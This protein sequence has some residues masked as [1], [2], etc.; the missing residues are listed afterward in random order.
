LFGQLLTQDNNGRIKPVN[1]LASEVLRKLYYK[2]TYKGMNPDQVLLGMFTNPFAWQYEPLIRVTH[3]QIKKILGSESGKY[4]S[5]ASFF[6]NNEYL[7]QSYVNN[8]YN[9]SP[10]SRNKFDNEMIRVDERVNISYMIFS[11]DLLKILPVPDDDTHTWYSYNQIKGKVG[12]PDSVFLENVIL[13][14]INDVRQALNTGDWHNADNIIRAISGYQI[15]TDAGIVPSTSKIQTEILL[16]KTDLIARIADYY[17]IAG[18]I[19]LIFQVIIL[20]NSHVKLKLPVKVMTYLIV[21]LFIAH[22]FSLAARWYVSG[23]APWSNG[24]E[25]LIYLSWATVLAGLILAYRSDITMSATA[26]LSFLILRIAHLSFM[27]PQITN[28]VPVLKS[29]WLVLHVSVITASYGFLALGAVLALV[30]LLFM[31][32]FTRHNASKLSLSIRE[33][34]CIIEISLIIGLYLIA[35][36]TFLG[37]VWANES[38]GRYWGW[39]PKETWALITILVYAFIT[40]MQMVPSLKGEF[41]FNLASLTGISSVLMTFFGVNYYLSGLHSYA[42]SDPLKIPIFVYLIIACIFII[43]IFARYKYK[44]LGVFDN[45]SD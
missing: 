4:F 31:T 36:G 42:S 29:F 37:G 35:V 5:F 18:I 43:S 11:G 14:Y 10:G 23:H 12:T 3:P 34:S 24:F 9:K 17:G 19:L 38:W 2:N 27:D 16:N 45:P 39:D 8:S 7:L 33:L 20:F 1:T 22:T 30:N 21:L 15:K 32:M 44:R 25:V 13:L 26:I 41:A 28:L 6:R 40:H